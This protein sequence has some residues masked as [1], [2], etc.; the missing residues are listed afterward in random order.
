MSRLVLCETLALKASS[1]GLVGQYMYSPSNSPEIG[2]RRTVNL[3]NGL[4]RRIYRVGYTV[5]D[6]IYMGYS[7]T[8]SQEIL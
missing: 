3:Q 8:A 6:G 4:F 5:S 1:R 7:C 2:V